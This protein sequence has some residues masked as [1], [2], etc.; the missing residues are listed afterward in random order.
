[1]SVCETWVHRRHPL[2]KLVGLVAA[3]TTAFCGIR[4][5]GT[6]G[7]VVVLLILLW[8]AG[9]APWQ[10]SGRWLL[11]LL[12]LSMVFMHALIFREGRPLIGPF[13]DQGLY[14]GL[15]IAARLV[16]LILAG[17]LF[18]LTTEP[19]DLAQLLIGLGLPYRWAYALITSL[20][21]E[22]L[23]SQ[24]AQVVYWA[25]LTRG[26]QYRRA[27][28]WRRWFMFRRLLIPLLIY[29]LRAARDLSGMMEL[30]GFGR[31]RRR[32]SIYPIHFSIV[33]GVALVS[34]LLLCVF[35]ALGI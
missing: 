8:Q 5:A 6:L 29:A 3:M 19:G 18:A 27:P 22:P 31:Y 33:D 34:C 13:T 12:V 17:R 26:V 11:L 21:L 16:A 2:V 4:L 14:Q 30:R 9:R 20:R 25:Q 35:L 15:H 24:Q 1:M 28:I 23:F 10:L 7:L 32:S